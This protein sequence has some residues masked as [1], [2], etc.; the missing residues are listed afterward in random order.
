[1]KRLMLIL[2]GGTIACT[3]K[4]DGLSPSLSQSDFIRFLPTGSEEYEINAMDIFN[5]DSTLISPA[6]W[7]SIASLVSENRDKYS[8]FII[9]HGTDTMAYTAAALTLMLSGIDRPVILTGS[10]LPLYAEG[11]DA[12]RNLS[13]AFAFA[14]HGS[15]TGVYISFA[16][17][18]IKGLYA[19][20]LYSVE[21]DAFR[22]INETQ[23]G[24]IRESKPYILSPPQC[25]PY[26]YSPKLDT[27]VALFKPAPG[28][29]STLRLMLGS[30]RLHGI[31]IEGFGSGSFP[32]T[33][34][35][36][37]YIKKSNDRL[38]TAVSTDCVYGGV[39]QK[40]YKVGHDIADAGVLPCVR[41]TPESSVVAM[42]WAL[43]NSRN[44]EKAREI[45]LQICC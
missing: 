37:N 16:G 41:L 22:S 26:S 18:L 12:A 29:T 19:K 45:F 20:K 3:R 32:Y 15:L 42:M 38:I 36:L 35:L 27:R 2:T 11:S 21:L 1:M 30:G 9:A 43:A 25:Q 7:Q 13:D 5:L 34:E 28:D 17:R 31:V 23:A 44:I 8:G 40:T 10:Q 14:V 4:D 33:S 39:N 24:E 6:H